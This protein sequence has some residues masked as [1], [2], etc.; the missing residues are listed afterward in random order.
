MGKTGSCNLI[1][2]FLKKRV[3]KLRLLNQHKF[4]E[5]C[6]LWPMVC[7]YEKFCTLEPI[8]DISQSYQAEPF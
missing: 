6:F 3:L 8:S 7:S 2:L 5:L 4:Y 1:K